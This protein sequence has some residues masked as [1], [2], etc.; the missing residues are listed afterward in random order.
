MTR[1]SDFWWV[2]LVVSLLIQVLAVVVFRHRRR[3]R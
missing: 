3:P 1:L 2:P